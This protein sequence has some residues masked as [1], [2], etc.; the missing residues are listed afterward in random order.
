[1]RSFA[2]HRSQY[3]AAHPKPQ[4]ATDDVKAPFDGMNRRDPHQVDAALFALASPIARGVILADEVGLVKTI[5]A[6]L[7][8]PTEGALPAAL[9][10]D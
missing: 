8:I 4:A 6:S 7:V 9:C 2:L 10:K 5:E 3:L 1:M